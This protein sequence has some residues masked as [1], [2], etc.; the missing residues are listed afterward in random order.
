MSLLI[1]VFVQ[2]FHVQIAAVK[3]VYYTRF[4]QDMLEHCT[5]MLHEFNSLEAC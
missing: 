5:H 4:V 1:P 2:L 3:K